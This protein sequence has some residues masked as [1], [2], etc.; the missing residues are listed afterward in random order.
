MAALA[1]AIVG[2]FQAAGEREVEAM[3]LSLKV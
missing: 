1:A 3:P 2:T